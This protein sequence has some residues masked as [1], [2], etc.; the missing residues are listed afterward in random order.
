MVHPQQSSDLPQ[1]EPLAIIEIQIGLLPEGKP[2]QHCFQHRPLPQVH[3]Q[4]ASLLA[5]QQPIEELSVLRNPFLPP[6]QRTAYSGAVPPRLPGHLGLRIATVDTCQIS[7]LDRRDPRPGRPYRQAH[8]VLFRGALRCLRAFH[9]R[10]GLILHPV[11]PPAVHPG[12]GGTSTD[13]VPGHQLPQLPGAIRQILLG[14]GQFQA[15]GFLL[16]PLRSIQ[17]SLK[18]GLLLPQYLDSFSDL[19][20]SAHRFS[21]LIRGAVRSAV[22]YFPL[23]GRV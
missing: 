20:G 8:L 2:V 6:L 17:L 11:P 12:P 14:P 16:S 19:S 23:L 21:S 22:V 15:E 10:P 1:G 4:R 3:H 13:L 18:G 5:V 9:L 7:F